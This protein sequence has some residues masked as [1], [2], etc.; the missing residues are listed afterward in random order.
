M[1]PDEK[2]EE[3]EKTIQ[4]RSFAYDLLTEFKF[5]NKRQ[6][7]IILILLAALVG[8]NM[9]WLWVFQSYDYVEYVQD[10]EG[11]NNI[12]MSN[13]GDVYN[14]NGTENKDQEEKVR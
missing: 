5:V 4:E 13:Q 1:N 14:N 9:T 7:W 8:T 2:L 3:I 11:Y 12:N 10:G 6:F